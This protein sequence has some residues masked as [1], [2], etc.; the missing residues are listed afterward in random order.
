[1]G[2]PIISMAMRRVSRGSLQSR[3]IA[4]ALR[5]IACMFRTSFSFH[6]LPI[7]DVEQAGRR[8][9][10]SSI[11]RAAKC[12]PTKKLLI[13]YNLN[14]SGAVGYIYVRKFTEMSSRYLI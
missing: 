2:R 8:K 12:E 3:R 5:R 1:L 9:C 14:E 11:G 4:H 6:P 13:K 7:G 10:V